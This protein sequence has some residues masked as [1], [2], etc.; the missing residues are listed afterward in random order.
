M[1]GQ[2]GWVTLD[3]KP[4]DYALV[5]FISSPANQGK[6]HVALGMFYPFPVWG[7]GLLR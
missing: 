6:P 7:S 4:G 2:T 1:P 5:C 3:L